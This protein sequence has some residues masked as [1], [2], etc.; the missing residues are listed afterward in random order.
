MAEFQAVPMEEVKR[1]ITH[2]TTGIGVS[3]IRAA[4]KDCKD[5]NPWDLLEPIMMAVS[6]AESQLV[7]LA[8]F[9]GTDLLNVKLQGTSQKGKWQNK[10]A[11][12]A[13]HIAK[14]ENGQHRTEKPARPGLSEWC[15]MCASKFHD[16]SKCHM[17]QHPNANKD[18]SVE[19]KDSKAGSLQINAG[20]ASTGEGKSW[21]NP[22]KTVKERPDGTFEVTETSTDVHDKIKKDVPQSTKRSAVNFDSYKGGSKKY[23]NEDKFQPKLLTI[24]EAPNLLKTNESL[25]TN[26]ASNSNQDSL[27]SKTQENSQ[28]MQLD[29]KGRPRKTT[30]CKVRGMIEAVDSEFLPDTG[31]TGGD[32][33][34]GTYI[35]RSFYET[36]KQ[37]LKLQSFQ[38]QDRTI[39]RTATFGG[40]PLVISEHT[41][42]HIEFKSRT[43]KRTMRASLKAYIAEDLCVPIIVGKNDL[44]H[45]NWIESRH[46]WGYGE[47]FIAEAAKDDAIMNMLEEQLGRFSMEG[48]SSL[49]VRAALAVDATREETMDLIA[50]LSQREQEDIE[51]GKTIP[52][53]RSGGEDA[54]DELY[55]KDMDKNDEYEEGALPTQVFG[56]PEFRAKMDEMH[57]KYANIFSRSLAKL[58]ADVPAFKFI[59]DKEKWAARKEPKGIRPISFPKERALQQYLEDGIGKLFK[60]GTAEH[61]S[62]VNM[63]PKGTPKPG[64]Q[65][66]YRFTCDFRELN[67]CC[68]KQAY[69]LPRIQE[70]FR[71]IAQSDEKPQ[72]FAKID[73]TQGFH[74]VPLDPASQEYSA[75]KTFRGIFIYLRMPM[76]IKGASQHFQ[77]VMQDAFKHV[78]GFGTYI[79][80]YIDDIW[81]HANTEERLAQRLESVYKAL[82]DRK[83]TINPKK[84]IIGA[85][86]IEYLGYTITSKGELKF[87][88]DKRRA[89]FDFPKPVFKKQLKSFL[90]IVN[91][92]RA[93]LDQYGVVSRP[94]D[95]MCGGYTTNSAKNKVVW[96]EES[97]AAFEQIKTLIQNMPT[98][99]LK[100]EKGKSRIVLRTDASDYGCGAHLVQKKILGL[101]P[102]G[103]EILGDDQTVM[104][105]SK[106]FDATQMNWCTA[107]KECYAVWYAC[108]KLQ[109]LLEGETFTIE[110]DHKNLTILDES[111]NQKVQRWKS[112]L[113]RF[114]ATWR[115]IKGSTNTVA[116]G[117]SRIVEIP[118]ERE[119]D[120]KTYEEKDVIVSIL[121]EML[122]TM[123]ED[124]CDA[125]ADDELAD[126]EIMAL[127]VHKRRRKRG[128]EK[129]KRNMT[130]A[131]QE[132]LVTTIRKI[133][134]A[135]D[136]HMGLKRTVELLDA[137]LLRMTT[138]NEVPEG[139]QIDDITRIMRIMAVKDYIDHCN[140][141]Q[142]AGPN[143]D[144]IEVKRYTRSSYV[145]HE[146]IEIDHVGPF[147]ADKSSGATHILV[148]IDTFSRW[149]EL[150]PTKGAGEHEAALAMADYVFRYG[151]P[152][153]CRSDKGSAFIGGIFAEMAKAARMELIQPKFAASHEEN[154]IVERCNKEVRRHLNAIMN[155]SYMKEDW[156]FA[157]KMVQRLL[158]N[159]R[160]SV[161]GV[162]PARIIYGEL[163]HG[164][165][166]PWKPR[167]AEDPEPQTW[168]NSKIQIQSE[169]IR[170]MQLNL[171]YNDMINFEERT[172]DDEELATRFLQM[173]EYVLYKALDRKSKATLHWTGPYQISNIKG[174]WYEL[175]SLSTNEKP[176]FAHARQLKRYNEDPSIDTVEVAYRDDMGPFS[177]ILGV[178]NPNRTQN[179]M[180]NVLIGVTYEQYPNSEYWIPIDRM[181]AEK[182]FVEYCC[183]HHCYSWITDVAWEKH[184][185]VMDAHGIRRKK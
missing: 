35:S 105:V 47:D 124:A 39:I 74:Q 173:K 8:Q 166:F 146:C 43:S 131:E 15:R 32:R 34:T 128:K 134:N 87:N 59:I 102:D 151:P 44:L 83:L 25:I 7:Y 73:L 51:A 175:V 135:L 132:F 33:V 85:D 89:L 62:P 181:L 42:I 121:N 48:E 24:E 172:A 148:V 4:L 23:K 127:H 153:M 137:Y 53:N 125:T 13:K 71:R 145:P 180:K 20:V 76:G 178:S 57:K 10:S 65:A 36:N 61:T 84:T 18:L 108:T 68:G 54:E 22:R 116:D 29:T 158:N 142:K 96:D 75:F 136:G 150:Y 91:T 90:G 169:L 46:L 99:H 182:L 70:I 14:N 86:E 19:W 162:E 174:D 69:P 77:Y 130:S 154:S 60:H 157:T 67:N 28:D 11:G 112:F 118:Q 27:S 126:G 93:R 111:A 177:S 107:E 97:S 92:F 31:S 141:C 149:I 110:V 160:H 139:I 156:S 120:I 16:A 56:T 78:E 79:Q 17:K 3:A 12:G 106:A 114:D 138:D 63:V 94:L 170:Y 95:I 21:L 109:Y 49:V 1:L 80:L 140:I 72:F 52:L 66:E 144:R 147:Q 171:E 179:T 155:E 133:H 50:H 5:P 113:Q 159:S 30:L 104:F 119:K 122:D 103:T 82:H 115:Y 184:A 163:I 123:E 167:G 168:F 81:V 55:F 41:Y 129:Q 143:G 88:E 37:K 101:Q 9:W 164:P 6:T 98:L 38:T 2:L 117:M 58:P 45:N 26:S 152:K 100:D 161:T 183:A 185:D 176:F 64:E 165:A 40:K